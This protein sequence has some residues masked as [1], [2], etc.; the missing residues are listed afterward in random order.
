MT[1]ALVTGVTGFVGSRLAERLV[2][3][4]YD[5][6]GLV[7]P[8]ASR[9]LKLIEPFLDEMTLLTGDV[10]SLNS[11]SN[12]LRNANPDLIFHLGALSPVRYSFEHPFQYQEANYMGTLNLVHSLM[13]L[14]DF[15]ERRLL[16]ASTAE[17]YG[18]QTNQPFKEDLPLRPTSPY[19]VSKAS[20][21]MYLRMAARVFDLNCVVM[22]PAN[23]YGRKREKGFIV[24]YLVTSMLSGRRVYVGAPD[25]V[26]DYIHVDDHVEAYVLAAERD[27][28]AGKVFN[29][30]SGVGIS[31]RDLAL[32]C[33]KILH[34]DAS[35]IVFGSYPPGYP[36]RPLVSD[37]PYIV[38]DSTRARE[39]LSWRPKVRLE[40]GLQMAVDYW[41]AQLSHS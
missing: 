41:K 7:R 25:S 15:K 23:T 1:T 13:E 20:M 31:N 14:R 35:N 9:D 22:R 18:I 4:G 16:V 34:Y 30:G 33:S 3:T 38:L 24:E 28:A 37:Q 11:V 5:V 12:I 26:R 8:C 39:E 19:A 29:F 40:E 17:V 6:F 32:L 21:D 2:E 10:T 36:M 27:N